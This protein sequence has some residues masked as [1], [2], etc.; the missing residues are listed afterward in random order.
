VNDPKKATTGDAIVIQWRIDQWFP[1]LPE[2]V[3]AKLKFFHE[4]LLKANK[5]I[6][7][8]SVKTIPQADAIHFADS[9]LA[10][11]AIFKAS[12]I[13]EI[14]DFGSGNGFPGLVFA[15]MFPKIKVH[16]VE[17]DPRKV[18]YL[19]LMV[20][21]MK[22]TN[23]TVIASAIEALPASSVKYGMSRGFA[24]IS[25]A[26][27]AS[28]KVFVKG[29][30]YFHLKGEEWASEVATIPTQLCSFWSPGLIGEYKLPVGEVKFAI[31]N[32]DKTA[33]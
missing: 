23:T 28:R 2:D 31:V 32:T 3:R 30:R 18:E 9:I 4:E 10:S 5:S 15:I 13:E 21:A 1:E 8:I 6:S 20:A 25:K 24:S 7:L 26:I 14:Y 22:L 19:K 17:M 16:L 29:G 27:L 33:D 12:K 11:R